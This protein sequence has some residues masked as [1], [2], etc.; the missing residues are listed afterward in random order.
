M[1]SNAKIYIAGHR[2]LVGSAL[3]RCLQAQGYTDIVT[4]T[5]AELD[6]TDRVATETFFAAEKPEY[7]F[8]AAAKVGGIHANNIYPGEFIFTNL[9][10]QTNVIH[11]AYLS[12]V[13]RLLFLGSSCIYPRDCPQPIKEEYLLTGPL[14]STNRPYA[15]AKIAGIEQCWSYNRQY[16][17]KFLA[18]MPTNLYGPG[19]NYDLAN[20]HVI[21]ALIR[22]FHEAKERGDKE[23]MVWGTG[24]PRREFLYSDDMVDA[25]VFLMSRLDDEFNQ[26]LWPAGSPSESVDT[27][28]APFINIGAGVDLTIR[29]LAE[30][31][32]EIVGYT[33]TI[34][35]DTSKP[36]GTPRKLLDVS[37][38]NALGWRAGMNL[39]DRLKQSY[40]AMQNPSLR[41]DK[42]TAAER[43]HN[44][45][46]H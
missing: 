41:H 33:G 19:D 13:E 6:L 44:I 34:M 25:C 45:I 3:M 4:R 28:L 21:P 11:A 17:T 30:C 16:G 40:Q 1:N 27:G 26:L 36:D 22:K 29:E 31:V 12:G 35:L 46:L 10:I 23:V 14:E 24:T 9:A 32:R 15:I 7:V 20:S 43:N 37:R 39:K 18:A 2:G 38:M 42:L 8:L 5:H